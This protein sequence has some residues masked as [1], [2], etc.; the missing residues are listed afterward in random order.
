MLRELDTVVLRDELPE[1]GLQPGDIG[2]VVLEH[3]NG[4]GYEVEFT[5]LAGDT[6]AVVTL[7]PSQVR[8]ITRYEVPH[9]R[10]VA[11]LAA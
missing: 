3:R 11:R 10:E 1:Y 9:A 8:A 7:L 5:T 2:T 6:L 4:A